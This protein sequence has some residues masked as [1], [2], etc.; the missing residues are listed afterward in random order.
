MEH[1]PTVCVTCV[2]ACLDKLN[3][4]YHKIISIENIIPNH[5][6]GEGNEEMQYD[7]FYAARFFGYH[8]TDQK[9]LDNRVHKYE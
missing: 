8:G 6:K 5:C 7:E 4:A 2:W 1:T 9:D 3:L